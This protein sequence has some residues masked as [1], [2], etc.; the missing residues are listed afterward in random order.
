MT[1]TIDNE[2]I[3]KAAAECWEVYSRQ[4]EQDQKKMFTN[5]FV[6]GYQQCIAHLSSEFSMAVINMFCDAMNNKKGE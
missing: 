5:A 3:N 4:K 2:P 6:L 1:L